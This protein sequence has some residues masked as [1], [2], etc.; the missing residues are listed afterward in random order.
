MKQK[1][2]TSLWTRFAPKN[3]LSPLAVVKLFIHQ[4]DKQDF[5]VQMLT[6]VSTSNNVEVSIVQWL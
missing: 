2:N 3:Q 4:P 5:V 6:S 1:K